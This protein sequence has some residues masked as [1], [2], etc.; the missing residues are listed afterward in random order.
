MV[1]TFL[2]KLI[3]F[4][5]IMGGALL[6]FLGFTTVFYYLIVNVALI[7]GGFL[8]LSDGL[9]KADKLNG[10][11]Q[12]NPNNKPNNH[13]HNHQNFGNDDNELDA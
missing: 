6:I 3:A 1:K 13:N 8:I 7:L 9:G 5:E 12:N 4:G 2:N 11:G 10:I